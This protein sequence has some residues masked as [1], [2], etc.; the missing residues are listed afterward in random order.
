MGDFDDDFLSVGQPETE[1][2]PEEESW[3]DRKYDS[4]PAP[5]KCIECGGPLEKDFECGSYAVFKCQECGLNMRH[6]P[7]ELMTS[8][9]DDKEEEGD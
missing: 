2:E 4:G 5:T 8:W 6:F 7:P 3:R 1:P 9:R